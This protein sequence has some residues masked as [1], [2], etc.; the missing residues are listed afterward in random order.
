VLYGLGFLALLGVLLGVAALL[1]RFDQLIFILPVGFFLGAGLT[2]C[3]MGSPAGRGCLLTLGLGRSVGPRLA[4][5][6]QLVLWLLA[7]VGSLIL[8]LAG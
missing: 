4:P 3:L 2:A 7:G 5:K 6:Y 8:A 1:V